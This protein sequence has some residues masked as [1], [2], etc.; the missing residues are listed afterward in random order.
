[1]RRF[2]MALLGFVL[3]YPVFAVVGYF[4]IE[5]LSDNQFDRSVEAAMTAAFAIG[6]LGA[7]IGLIA[8][9]I[10]GKPRRVQDPLASAT[11]RVDGAR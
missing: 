10:L 1:M 5:L 7:V 3:G 9:I 4:A 8:G 11:D 6:P 2:L